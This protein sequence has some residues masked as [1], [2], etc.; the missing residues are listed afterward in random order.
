MHEMLIC[1]TC[2]AAIT[3][4]RPQDQGPVPKGRLVE[5]TLPP[6]N[7]VP[8]YDCWICIKFSKWLRAEH[9]ELL[10]N[11]D[12]EDL[13]VTY[14][15]VGWSHMVRPEGFLLCVVMLNI[16]HRS[17]ERND[18]CGFELDLVP[19]E[20]N[21]L[22]PNTRNQDTNGVLILSQALWLSRNCALTWISRGSGS[23]SARTSTA[24]VYS[25]LT[26]GT[27]RGCCVLVLQDWN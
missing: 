21:S 14:Y 17:L 22:R 11:W 2:S 26:N 18:S 3:T 6:L 25:Q 19:R 10:R 1:T 20:G 5:S 7:Q 13:P 9:P 23:T 12:H 16:T 8:R 27:R 4:L 24:N 15:L